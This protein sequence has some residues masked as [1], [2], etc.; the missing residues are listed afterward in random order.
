MTPPRIRYVDLAAHNAPLREKLLAAVDRVLTH[1]NFIL[2]PEVAQLEKALASFLDVPHVVG[3][4]NGTDAL[5]LGLKLLGVKAGDE[6]I[7]PSHSFVATATSI[8]LLGAVPVLVDIDERTM[9]IDPAAVK[10][11]LTPKTR[12]VMPVHLS[13]MPA[14]VEALAALCKSAGISMLEDCAQSIGTKSAG[15]S[16]GSLGVGC[17]SLHPLKILSALGDAGFITVQTEAQVTELKRMRNIGLVDRDHCDSVDSNMRL[18]TIHASMLLAKLPHVSEWIAARRAHAAAYREA[19]KGLVELPAE[20]GNGFHV[21]SAFVIRH[22]QRDALAAF[23]AE[24]G[25][26]AKIHYPIPIHRQKAFADLKHG[27]LPVTE[28]VCSTILSL[29]VTPELTAAH[30]TEVIDGIREFTATKR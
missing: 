2:G 18:D 13:G 17:F 8:R 19:L 26:E 9:N 20:E 25:I 1:G 6:V 28:R 30:R 5:V 23:L 15:R 11:A 21:Y 24:R 12:A 22:P 3:V 29:P 14:P 10:A 7:C 16:V 27:P 4:S